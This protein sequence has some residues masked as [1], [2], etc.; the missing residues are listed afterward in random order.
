MKCPQTVLPGL[1]TVGIALLSAAKNAVEGH[2]IDWSATIAAVTAGLGL[3]RC[4]QTNVTSEDVMG[5]DAA[6]PRAKVSRP[7][8]LLPLLL[9]L[10]LGALAT[11]CVRRD[12]GDIVGATTTCVGIDVSQTADSGSPHF[13][14]GYIRTQYHLV[15]TV[16]GSNSITAPDVASSISTDVSLSKTEINEDFATGHAAQDAVM[17]EG[18]TTARQA[19]TAKTRHANPPPTNAA[20][21][22][23]TGTNSTSRKPRRKGKKGEA[24]P[25]AVAEEAPED[26]GPPITSLPRAQWTIVLQGEGP[27]GPGDHAALIQNLFNAIAGE[28]L[29]QDG[30]TLR[31]ANLT[32]GQRVGPAETICTPAQVEAKA[33]ELFHLHHPGTKWEDVVDLD[34]DTAQAWRSLAEQE[35]TP[36]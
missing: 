6:K 8:L 13:R 9:T 24:A 18:Q 1:I 25:A 19:V 12:K 32:I 35:L 16:K 15:P 3:M 31:V 23:P 22:P 5:N 26:D 21:L 11:G 28:L 17:A 34:E 20:A 36:R 10:S 2:P 30:H 7:S 33:R 29:P 14:I 4:R 27:S